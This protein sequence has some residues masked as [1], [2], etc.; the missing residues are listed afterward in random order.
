MLLNSAHSD[1]KGERYLH[2]AVPCALVA[3]GF[4]AAGLSH[5]P[6]IVLPGFACIMMGLSAIAA[7]VWSIPSEFLA[8][9]SAA[10]GVAAVN[11]IAI[12]GGFLGPYWMGLA[13]DLTGN[14]QRGL[15]TLVVPSLIAM[16]IML[17]VRCFTRQN[18]AAVAMR[19][20]G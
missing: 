17:G 14:Y 19:A 2:L 6:A 11:M 5:R 1:H 3:A 15:L 13:A 9:R 10:A 16:L 18:H 20:Q 8:G 12:L 7:P 4:A